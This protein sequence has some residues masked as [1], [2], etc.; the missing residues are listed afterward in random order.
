MKNLYA[1]GKLEYDAYIKKST[2]DFPV[3]HSARKRD[4][5]EALRDLRTFQVH[6]HVK[7]ELEAL[8]AAGAYQNPRSFAEVE[9]FKTYFQG[10]AKWRRP[11]LLIVGGT[12]LGKSMLGGAVLEDIA[13]I[14]GLQKKEFLEVTVDR[15]GHLDLANGH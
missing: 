9:E 15:D 8:R 12:N 5:E 11:I 14:L 1:D 3:G 2:A 4:A 7:A 6:E 10:N 13:G